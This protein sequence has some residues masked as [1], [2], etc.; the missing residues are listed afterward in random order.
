M[1]RTLTVVAL[2]VALS[3]AG[4]SAANADEWLTECNI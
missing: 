1:I 3:T 4:V 2:V